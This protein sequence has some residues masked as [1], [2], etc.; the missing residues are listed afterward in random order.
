MKIFLV[1]IGTLV[2]FALGSSSAFAQPSS[3]A[4]E[5]EE[6][7]VTANRREQSLQEVAISV[8]AFTSE[9]FKDSGTTSLN[10]LEQYTP[11][12]KCRVWRGQC[13]D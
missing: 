12:L 11:S 10:Q 5:L 2:T 13:I 6:V 7:I 3:E 9:F 8:A 1:L 4:V